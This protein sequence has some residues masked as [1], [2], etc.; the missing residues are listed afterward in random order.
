[1]HVKF[2]R[3]FIFLLECRAKSRLDATAAAIQ[4]REHT[5]GHKATKTTT[6][7]KTRVDEGSGHSWELR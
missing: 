1:M 6:M 2:K 7:T 4:S 5:A 3:S